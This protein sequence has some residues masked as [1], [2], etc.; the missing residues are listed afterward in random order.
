LFAREKNHGQNMNLVSQNRRLAGRLVLAGFDGFS[1]PSEI[2]RL[3][4]QDSLFGIILFRRN[5]DSVEQVSSLNE[6]ARRIARKDNPPV[7]AVDQEGGR[8]VRMR[9]PLTALPCARAFG[10]KNDSLLTQKAGLLVGRELSSLGFTLNF[11][12][13]L[14]V[15]TNPTSPVI[16]DRSYGSTLDKVIGHGLA[17]AEGLKMGGV[18]PC[19]KHFPGHGDASLDSHLALPTVPHG[20]D[21]LDA[22]EIAPFHAWSKADLGPVMTA[23]VMYPALDEHFPAT[24]SSS[25]I[26]GVL[27]RR[28][29]FLGPVLTDD[30]EMGAMA[31][32]GGPGGAAVRAVRAGADG[33][34]VCHLLEHIEAVIE[35]VAKEASEDVSFRLRV[36]QAASRLDYLRN[37][38]VCDLSYIGSP[39]HRALAQEVIS[40][41]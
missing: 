41:F 7:V 24:L 11:A 21:R 29:G 15:D 19:A 10:G 12:P 20:L 14:D 1:L 27:R 37:V 40:P 35:A 6:S 13:V 16:G 34:L 26:E 30:L 36:E 4:E 17:F 9:E 3:L 31:D 38:H 33:L 39:A 28:I 32:F 22:V 18:M 5:V 25:I 23:H 2:E 8:V